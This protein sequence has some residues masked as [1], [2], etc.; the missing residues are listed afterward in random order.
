[1]L[2]IYLSAI[3]FLNTFFC[4]AEGAASPGMNSQL[5]VMAVFLG[6]F[7]FLV[8][9]PQ[10][11]KAK[12]HEQLINNLKVGDEVVTAAGILGKVVKLKDNYIVVSISN[13]SE[14][15]IRR[16]AIADVVPKGTLKGI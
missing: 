13:E 9:R 6:A 1:M 8:I 11:K 7:Y 2:K 5:L 3:L 14:V 15:V 12:E 4:L 16:S 10:N